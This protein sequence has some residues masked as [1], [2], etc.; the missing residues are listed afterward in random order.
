MGRSAKHISLNG[1]RN[2]VA[3][4]KGTTPA[5]P[6]T[7]VAGMLRYNTTLNNLEYYNGTT[8]LQ[9]GGGVGGISEI[10]ADTITIDGITPTL[11]YTMSLPVAAPSTEKNI[12]VFLEGVYQK[13]SSYTVSGTTIT[14][15]AVLAG[16][17]GKTLTVLHGF[18]AV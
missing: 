3:L 4:P 10:T 7:A 16:D 17:N 13:P 11:A 14:L 18:D 8:F 12:L 9:V 1:S 5:Q 2:S 15:S 6:T